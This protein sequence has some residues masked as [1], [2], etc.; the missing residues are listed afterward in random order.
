MIITCCEV[1]YSDI[2]LFFISFK[3][4]YHKVS[5]RIHTD[6]IVFKNFSKNFGKFHKLWHQLVVVPLRSLLLV[7][8]PFEVFVKRRFKC[9]CSPASILY[10][11]IIKF[12]YLL[13]LWNHGDEQI[14]RI[15][16]L[17]CWAIFGNQNRAVIDILDDLFSKFNPSGLEII[18]LESFYKVS[19]FQTYFISAL[20][21]ML[22]FLD[23]PFCT[24]T[25]VFLH[26]CQRFK[27]M[28]N[29]L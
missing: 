16:F 13:L 3:S 15:H 22:E 18:G 24:L 5:I 14:F 28:L 21:A 11:S 4:V 19:K 26:L 7:N 8:K 29:R 2:K 1:L 20:A 6:Y 27:R 9:I 10:H 12:L 17:I 23:F 25:G